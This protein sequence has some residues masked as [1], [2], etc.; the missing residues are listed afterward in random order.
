MEAA[1]VGRVQRVDLHADGAPPQLAVAEQG[2]QEL[3]YHVDRDREADAVGVGAHGRVDPHDLAAGVEERA[4]GVA[5]VDAGVGLEEVE[6]SA[7]I[8]AFYVVAGATL[9]REDAGG[10]GVGEAERVADGHDPVAHVD[11][12]GVAERDRGEARLFDLED[13][14]VGVLV[15]TDDGALELAA[16]EEADHHVGRIFDHVVVGEQVAV[17]I[18][19]ERGAEPLGDHAAAAALRRAF[20]AGFHGRHGG[21]G[22]ARERREG[23]GHALG[24]EDR[25]SRDGR[26]DGDR[27]SVGGDWQRARRDPRARLR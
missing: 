20:D 15:A 12:V 7:W 14:D 19:D 9:G 6:I 1:G 11:R 17:G 22:P 3:F 2:R 5:G 23:H 26:R 4:A 16:V 25:W 13:G 27:R 21:I 10:H 24:V 8:Q 18:V